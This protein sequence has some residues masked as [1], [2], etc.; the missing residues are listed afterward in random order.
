MV[1]DLGPRKARH[2]YAFPRLIL[3]AATRRMRATSSLS[4]KYASVRNAL[5]AL[6]EASDRV[7]G[8]RLAP[9]VSALLPAS[10]MAG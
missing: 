5:I 2:F 9:M 4:R 1:T 3:G 10:A 6:W 7:C 8:K